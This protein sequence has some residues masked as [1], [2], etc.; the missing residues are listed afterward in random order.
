MAD[1]YTVKNKKQ[2][3]FGKVGSSFASIP[4]G[5]VIVIFGCMMLWNNEK[6]NVINIKDVKEMRENIVQLDSTTVDSANEGKLVALS[7][8][9]DY[10]DQYLVDNTFGISVKTPVLEREV[11]VYEWIEESET[12]DE[13]TTYTYKKEWSDKLVDSS[14][15]KKTA[16][17]ENPTY[18]KYESEKYLAEYL[19]VGKF[20]LSENFKSK[21][22]ASKN[23]LELEP[24]VALLEG[25]T[26]NGKYITNSK[27]VEN[28]E[29]GDIRISYVYGEYDTVSVLGKQTGSKI[30][31]YTTKKNSSISRLES[32]EKT[33]DELINNI[34]S[35]NKFSKWLMRILGAILVCLGMSM[36]L[37]PLTTLIGYI[38]FLGKIVNGAIG[39][40]S[41]TVGLAISLITVTIAWLVYR[42]IIGIALIVVSVGLIILAKKYVS[43]K[44]DGKKPETKEEVKEEKEEENKEE[45]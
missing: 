9:L 29:V 14:N 34:E 39:V 35:G 6:K 5:I 2:G 41:T 26:V 25:Y 27:D 3:F 15:F 32:G 4:L 7:G 36:V 37:S 10:G 38:P 13:E 21:L 24:G 33:A 22:S 44:D 23:L 45:N 18:L 28:P 31:S 17:H 8:K 11:E 1:T 19:K 16:D 12:K 42:P 30:G 20:D 43:K 40:V